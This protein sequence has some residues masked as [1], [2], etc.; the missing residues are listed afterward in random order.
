M[1][2]L[3]IVDSRNKALS[4]ILKGNVFI[5]EKKIEKPGKIV[6]HNSVLSYKKIL[7]GKGFSIN[8]VK[9]SLYIT[10]RLRKL[11]KI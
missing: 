10:E 8:D 1:T 11:C 9:N 4:L 6:K 5:D 7:E 2:E 3:E